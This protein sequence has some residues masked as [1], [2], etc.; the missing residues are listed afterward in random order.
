MLTKKLT[1]YWTF[2]RSFWGLN[3]NNLILY[4]IVPNFNERLQFISGLL[5]Y[6]IGKLSTE[7]NFSGRASSPYTSK[8]I[9]RV[10]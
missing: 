1:T 6:Q 2:V 9:R 7:E 8:K 10:L 3:V 5:W 4:D